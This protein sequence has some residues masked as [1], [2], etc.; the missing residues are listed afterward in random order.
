[1]KRWH[2][3]QGF[4]QDFMVDQAVS[5]S[6][7]GTV[8]Q[9]YLFEC[10]AGDKGLPQWD[11]PYRVYIDSNNNGRFDRWNDQYLSKYHACGETHEASTTDDFLNGFMID[12]RFGHDSTPTKVII[13]RGDKND[14][15]HCTTNLD[16]ST[17]TTIKS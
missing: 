5:V 6:T 7:C 3:P 2:T 17:W 8:N 9:K 1:M 12:T 16:K 4:V 10:N 11:F 13:W 14:D 15:T